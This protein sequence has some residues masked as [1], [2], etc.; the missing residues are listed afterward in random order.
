MASGGNFFP[1]DKSQST[2]CKIFGREK[3]KRSKAISKIV[4]K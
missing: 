2:N 3:H 1:N 4:L